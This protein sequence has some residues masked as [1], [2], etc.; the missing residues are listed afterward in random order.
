MLQLSLVFDL[1]DLDLFFFNFPCFLVRWNFCEDF[2][3]FRDFTQLVKEVCMLLLLLCNQDCTLHLI[4]ET[5]VHLFLVLRLDF[6]LF[7][8]NLVLPNFFVINK[9]E[10]V[11][12]KVVGFV[13]SDFVYRGNFWR[14]FLV[15]IQN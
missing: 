3:S 7:V 1:F 14:C 4:W 12:V 5:I 9:D 2:D 11:L 15:R 6:F 8:S 13:F 10:H